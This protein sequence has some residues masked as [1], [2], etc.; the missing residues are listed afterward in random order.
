MT[1]IFTDSV[2]PIATASLDPS[3]APSLSSPIW[4]T[5]TV[6]GIKSPK[7]E[8]MVTLAGKKII[9]VTKYNFF[10]CTFELVYA[11]HKPFEME[12]E[13]LIKRTIK[14]LSKLPQDKVK[15]VSDF[16]DFIA[17]KHEEEFLQKGMKILVS[18]S[19]SF[20]FLQDEEDLYTVE[21]LKEKYK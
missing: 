4:E 8:E 11:L 20:Y 10:F 3:V 12:K 14:T 2:S 1:R 16:A 7:K 19:K 5:H 17:K 6:Q 21:D 9:L 18:E 13:T 15:E